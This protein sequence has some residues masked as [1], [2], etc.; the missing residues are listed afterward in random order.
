MNSLTFFF[1]LFVWLCLVVVVARGV[2]LP[3][4]GPW[5]LLSQRMDSVVARG[6]SICDILAW[7]SP[8][9]GILI[10]RPGREPTSP[11][12]PGDSWTAREV[13]ASFFLV[14]DG[15]TVFF[16]MRAVVTGTKDWDCKSS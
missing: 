7:F 16:S 13:P 8:A 4:V 14:R 9:C 5:D 10:T 12:S 11:A 15:C 2:F 1:D 3:H 6:L